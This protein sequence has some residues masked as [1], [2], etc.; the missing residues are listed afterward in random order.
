MGGNV[1]NQN[2][3][4]ITFF[5][6]HLPFIALGI[7]NTHIDISTLKTRRVGTSWKKIKLKEKSMQ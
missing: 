3:T 2:C 4:D 6:L 7:L 1:K 5:L